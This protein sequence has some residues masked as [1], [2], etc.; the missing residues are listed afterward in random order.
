MRV[1]HRLLQ[2]LLA[3]LGLAALT[4]GGMIF[5]FGVVQTLHFFENAYGVSLSQPVVLE[6]QTVSV[7]IDNEFRFYAVFWFSYG[8]LCL[9]A[10][11]GIVERL[12]LVPLLFGIFF[13]GGIGRAISCFVLGWPHP[14]FVVLMA[15]EL[16]GPILG[17]AVYLR[18]PQF[19]AKLKEV[20]PPKK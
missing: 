11:K 3:P 4:I 1:E 15:I 2:G 13:L 17:A 16:I 10:A 8:V 12:R 7:T 18:I 5:T 20:V 9:W 6:P 14:L 19:K